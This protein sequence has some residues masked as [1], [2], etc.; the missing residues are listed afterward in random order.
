M[1]RAALAAALG[2]LVLVAGV[3]SVARALRRASAKNEK[4]VASFVGGVSLTFVVLDLF[5]ELFQASTHELHVRAGPEPEHT[6]AMLILAG[7]AA[8]LAANVYA[9]RRRSHAYAVAVVPFIL[10]ATL[11]GAALEEELHEGV[12]AFVIFA[13]AM[14]LHFGVAE[15]GL[16]HAFP[17]EH[18]G[19]TRVVT[20]FAPLIGATASALIE[21]SLTSAHEIV[22]VIAGATILSIFREEIPSPA[23]VKLRAFF[24][25]VVAFGALVYARWWL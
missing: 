16:D 17:D 15:H 21:P 5:V 12:G 25:G 2:T 1:H 14:M 20:I 8:G 22:A 6:I 24:A 9:G 23:D 18:R 13:L 19:L 11:V 10:Y 3:W 4:L 7:A